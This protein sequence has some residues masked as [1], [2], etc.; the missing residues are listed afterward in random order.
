MPALL[1]DTPGASGSSGRRSPVPPDIGWGRRV[2]DQCRVYAAIDLYVDRRSGDVAARSRDDPYGQW[3]PRGDRRGDRGRDPVRRWAAVVPAIVQRDADG[4][5]RPV[6]TERGP[7]P[8]R[9]PPLQRGARSPDTP[10]RAEHGRARIAGDHHRALPGRRGTVTTHGTSAVMNGSYDPPVS[11]FDP[12]CNENSLH[13]ARPYMHE[14]FRK[15]LDRGLD[16]CVY[17]LGPYCPWRGSY[18]PSYGPAYWP[19][20]DRDARRRR[21]ELGRGAA[22]ALDAAPVVHDVLPARRRFRG[23]SGELEQLS[24]GDPERRPDRRGPV[25]IPPGRP[26]LRRAHDDDR[27]QRPRRHDYDFTGHG[28]GCVGCRTIQF[29]AIGPGIK[30][31]HVSTVPRGQEDIAPTVGALL[32]FPAPYSTGSVMTE[33]FTSCQEDIRLRRPTGTRG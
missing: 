9:R 15:H 10:V 14:Y 18:H 33:I 22:A 24:G 28:D 19:R 23:H 31:G 17:V 4:T 8:H 32:G 27:H 6:H 13:S 5:R 2:V 11:F 30:S 1:H 16:D 12:I 20:L 25:G 29:L 7:G 26:P 3:P 21:C